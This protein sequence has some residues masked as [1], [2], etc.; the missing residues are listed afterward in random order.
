MPGTRSHDP[1]RARTRAVSMWRWCGSYRAS[2]TPCRLGRRPVAEGVVGVAEAHQ[3]VGRCRGPGRLRHRRGVPAA[4]GPRHQRRATGAGRSG[5]EWEPPLA[6][7]SN[8]L[9]IA[10]GL[11]VLGSLG[12]VIYRVRLGLPDGTTAASNVLDGARGDLPP[13]GRDGRAHPGARPHP[14]RPC[15]KSLSTGGKRAQQV[16]AGSRPCGHVLEPLR[17]RGSLN[18]RGTGWNA[19]ADAFHDRHGLKLRDVLCHHWPA[20]KSCR[21]RRHSRRRRSPW[22]ARTP[23]KAPA[24]EERELLARLPPRVSF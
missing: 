19:H 22:S 1:S 10:V 18:G 17:Q 8:E 4:H 11:T 16:R 6:Q 12:T 2:A 3:R 13:A 15:P 14:T 20:R 24:C 7:V 9:G 23:V 21:C 5:P